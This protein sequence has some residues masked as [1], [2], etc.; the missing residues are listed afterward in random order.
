MLYILDTNICRQAVEK[1]EIISERIVRAAANDNTIAT[2]IISFDESV[3][4]WLPRLDD[5]S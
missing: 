1:R 5:W 2:T 3:S 4:G